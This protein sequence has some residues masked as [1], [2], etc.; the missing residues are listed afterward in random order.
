M[1]S[2]GVES[3]QHFWLSG[4]LCVICL[5]VMRANCQ[6]FFKKSWERPEE[7]ETRKISPADETV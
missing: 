6:K 1:R 4:V 7:T 2:T 5:H 3:Q